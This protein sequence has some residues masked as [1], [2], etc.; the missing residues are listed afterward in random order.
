MSRVL[1]APQRVRMSE[2]GPGVIQL[3]RILTAHEIC[4]KTR[5]GFLNEWLVVQCNGQYCNRSTYQPCPLITAIK[6]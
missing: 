6:Y 2:V 5:I 1:D 3:N 4:L